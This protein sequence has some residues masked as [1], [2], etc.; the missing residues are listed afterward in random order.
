VP[1]G[2]A[3][4]TSGAP[5]EAAGFGPLDA[6]TARDLIAAA[7]R[8][9]DTR[10]CLTAL[11]PD[12][13]AAAHACAAGR[14][15]PPGPRRT[16]ST[17]SAPGPPGA[18]AGPDPP[19]DAPVPDLVRDL[20]GRL[21]LI[22]RGSCDHRHAEPGYVPSRRLRHLISAR[23]TQCAAPG[24]GRPAARCDLDHTVAWENGGITCECGLGPAC[25]HHHRCK[26]SQ[27]WKL[28]QPSPGVMVWTTPGGRTYTTTPTVY[29]IS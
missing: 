28:E 13:T 20:A 21:T 19:P 15:P 12:G 23:T 22:A 11:H 26:Q 17:P 27:G 29:T 14:H 6:D 10:W 4:G 25:R 3:L 16:S 18:R 9:P 24:C 8:H 5:G 1:L 2:T 7:A